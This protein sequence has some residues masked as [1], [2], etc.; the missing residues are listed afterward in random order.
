MAIVVEEIIF[1]KSMNGG[2]AYIMD[3]FDTDYIVK[4]KINTDSVTL[5]TDE[6][7]S[8]EEEEYIKKEI[9]IQKEWQY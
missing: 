2:R 4:F 9:K 7:L 8:K 1:N 6:P 5:D 3:P